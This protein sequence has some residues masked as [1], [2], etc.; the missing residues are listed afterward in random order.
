MTRRYRV[1]VLTSLPLDLKSLVVR[2]GGSPPLNFR[3]LQCS[4]A[5]ILDHFAD[6]AAFSSSVGSMDAGWSAAL[7]YN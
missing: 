4:K 7:L 1:T 5:S 3:Y 2:K 6:V